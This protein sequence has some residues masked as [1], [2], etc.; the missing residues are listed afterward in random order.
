M[1]YK[2]D[3]KAMLDVHGKRVGY[4]DGKT[5]RNGKGERVGSVS[6]NAIRDKSGQKVAQF[7]NKALKASSG[8]RLAAIQEIRRTIAGE[9]DLALCAVWYFFIYEPT[10]EK[11]KESHLNFIG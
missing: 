9:E 5:V 4:F 8:E 7:S 1:E 11:R 3:G 10:R 6:G 2:F